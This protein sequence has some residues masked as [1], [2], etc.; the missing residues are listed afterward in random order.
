VTKVFREEAIM[1]PTT[2]ILLAMA[3]IVIF[4]IASLLHDTRGTSGGRRSNNYGS[5]S[6][7][8]SC[9]S[10]FDIDLGD[11]IDAAGDFGGND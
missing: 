6:S 4:F 11:V 8:Y 10:G 1:S 2:I 5:G 7:D 9:G 3:G